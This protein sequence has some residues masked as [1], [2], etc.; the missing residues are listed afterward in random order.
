MYKKSPNLKKDSLN[1]T[2]SIKKSESPFATY[3]LNNNSKDDNIEANIHV[4]TNED[5]Y[6]EI[7]AEDKDTKEL[8]GYQKR[9]P[10]EYPG[11]YEEEEKPKKEEEKGGFDLLYLILILLGGIIIIISIC[12]CCKFCCNKKRNKNKL[13]KLDTI[14]NSIQNQPLYEQ[15]E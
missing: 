9:Y 15:D 14:T 13:S 11:D 2:I 5:F 8:L 3:K 4:Y 1:N 6:Y 12:L 10:G 7:I